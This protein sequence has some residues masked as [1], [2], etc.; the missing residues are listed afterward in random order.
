MRLPPAAPGMLAVKMPS[1]AAWS[2]PPPS[3]RMGVTVKVVVPSGRYSSCTPAMPSG[4]STRQVMATGWLASGR[5]GACASPEIAGGALAR[6]L[7]AIPGEPRVDGIASAAPPSNQSPWTP[8]RKKGQPAIQRPL[9]RSVSACGG[10]G[11]GSSAALMRLT[12]A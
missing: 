3:S 7:L 11:T 6:R 2:C 9:A 8:M 12:S 4:S 1:P 10:A 5:T